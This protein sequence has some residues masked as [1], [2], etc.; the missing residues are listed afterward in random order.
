MSM[1]FK[2]FIAADFSRIFGNLPLKYRENLRFWLSDWKTGEEGKVLCGTSAVLKV[3]DS[4]I[5]FCKGGV[6]CPMLLMATQEIPEDDTVFGDSANYIASF[7]FPIEV[8]K[9]M[10]MLRGLIKNDGNGRN[11]RVEGLR[12]LCEYHSWLITKTEPE[13]IRR[14]LI[15]ISR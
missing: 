6:G 12:W 9:D 14:L 11:D 10:E 7:Q 8:T 2:K 4:P 5:L 13:M 15:R 3:A 1:S